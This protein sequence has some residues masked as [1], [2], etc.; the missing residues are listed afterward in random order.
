MLQPPPR[1]EREAE[2]GI[3]DV[4]R[5]AHV[6]TATVSRALNRP[7]TVSAAVR[8]R[9][10]RAVEELG[11]VPHAAARAL[12]TR[13]SQTIGA[14]I[15]TIDNAIF[16][17]GIQAL[18]RHLESRE[19]HVLLAT[20]EYDPEIEERQA[21][22]LVMRGVDG[23]IFMGD[24]HT[25]RLRE[26]LKERGMPYVNTGVYRREPG[27]ACVG[28]DNRAAAARAAQHLVEL[29]HRRIAMIAGIRRHNDRAT[30]RVL[31]V[32]EALRAAGLS[33]PEEW[34]L[35]CRYDYNEA[36]Q[37]LRRLLARSPRP[38]AIVCGNDVLAIGALLEAQAAGVRVPAE[39]SIVGFDD[40]ELA[41]HLRPSLTTMRVP[42]EE[43]WCRAADYL[44]AV[45]ASSPAI[46]NFEIEVGLVVRESTGPCRVE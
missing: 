16:A 13:R 20:S 11:Y 23:L 41:R 24:S 15:P 22:N 31:G 18:N 28:F 32:S 46:D 4:A 19:Y 25:R 2:V 35:E 26:F 29:G 6:S 10:A 21:R 42:T 7:Q 34:I 44:L 12:T 38:T 30:D 36:G 9:V 43:M 1:K 39:L 5:R 3:R 8:S 37:A 27:E 17:K 33:L 40:L 14:V 45:L